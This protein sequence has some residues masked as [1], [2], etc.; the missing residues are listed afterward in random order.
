MTITEL[1][2]L[3]GKTALV[4]GASRGIGLAIAEGLAGAGARTILAA[5]SL[6]KLETRAA[7]IREQGQLAEALE[8][9]VTS[10]ESIRAAA[11][12]L[13]DVDILVNVAG[14]SIRKAF[15]D[16]TDEEYDLLM[17]TNVRGI[18]ELTRLVGDKMIARGAGG[19]VIMIGSM[20]T[21]IGLPFLSVYAMT[22]SALNGL[23]QV[24]AAEWAGHDIQVNCIAPGVIVT[25]LNR[26][27]WQD[28]AMTD[29][30]SSEQAHPGPGTPNDIVPMAVLLSGP[31]SNYLTGQIILIDGGFTKTAFWPLKT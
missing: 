28:P 19:K 6:E 20:A 24:L 5:R 27:V 3:S 13:G 2:S 18:V 14:T 23:T 29:W 26:Q 30:L 17:Q 9:D 12:K 1:F 4:A 25:D 11:G 31:G 21:A 22:K 16:T 10:S 7:A 15:G 8:L